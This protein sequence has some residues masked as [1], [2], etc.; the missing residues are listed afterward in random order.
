MKIITAEGTRSVD[1]REVLFIYRDKPDWLA[2]LHGDLVH[3][4]R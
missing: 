4:E 3:G 2:L 1:D